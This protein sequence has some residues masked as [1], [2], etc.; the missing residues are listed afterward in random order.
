VV[1][2]IVLVIVLTRSRRRQPGYAG[3]YPAMGAP[4]Y[5]FQLS[6]D[7]RYWWDGQAWQDT[8]VRI[9]PG[10]QVTPDRLQWFDGTRWRPVPP[11]PSSG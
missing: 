2:V 3:A 7:G 1:A 9:P 6:A 4:A 8:M 11:G 5:Q 10:A